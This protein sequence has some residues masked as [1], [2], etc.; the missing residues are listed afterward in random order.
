MGFNIAYPS[1][2]HDYSRL[3]TKK[4]DLA[5]NVQ[6][7]IKYNLKRDLEKIKKSTVDKDAWEGRPPQEVNAFYSPQSNKFI[8]LAGILHAPFFDINASDAAN[9]GGIGMANRT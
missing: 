2:W 9:Y 7:I 8:L 1:K 6:E 4:D 3:K 5:F